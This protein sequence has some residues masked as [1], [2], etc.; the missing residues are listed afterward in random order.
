MSGYNKEY[1]LEQ[2][3]L[4]TK[5]RPPDFNNLLKVLRREKPDR[6]TLFEFFLNDALYERLTGTRPEQDFTAHLC[7]VMEAY[8]NAGRY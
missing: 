5:N 1:S 3:L 8:R 4:R 2:V 7:W 6:P